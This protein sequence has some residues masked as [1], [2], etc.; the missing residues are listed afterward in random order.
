MVGDERGRHGVV[1]GEGRGRH[2]VWKENKLGRRSNLP[3]VQL[4]ISE[5]CEL[6]TSFYFSSASMGLRVSVCVSACECAM[7]NFTSILFQAS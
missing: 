3:T 2:W 6:F 4:N 1:R 7:F 5:I